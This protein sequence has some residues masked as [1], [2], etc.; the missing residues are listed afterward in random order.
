MG[1]WLTPL[2]AQGTASPFPCPFPGFLPMPC[3][4]R[5]PCR[6]YPLYHTPAM[7]NA[8]APV[9]AH[10]PSCP[11]PMPRPLHPHFCPMS[12]P[13]HLPP[14]PPGALCWPLW[15]ANTAAW[16]IF[17]SVN[18]RQSV[19]FP[20]DSGVAERNSLFLSLCEHILLPE[21]DAIQRPCR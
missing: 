15:W 16:W 11:R 9:P 2:E 1:K 14:A 5:I 6:C 10:A 19:A 18:R 4:Y 13:M 12:K 3:P 7:A 17:V 20:W 21:T 8:Q